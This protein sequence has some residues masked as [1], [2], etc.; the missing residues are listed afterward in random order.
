MWEYSMSKLSFPRKLRRQYWIIRAEQGVFSF[1]S[2]K[3]PSHKT[4]SAVRTK[5]LVP[6]FGLERAVVVQAT[7][8][9]QSVLCRCDFYLD[10]AEI[11]RMW[12]HVMCGGRIISYKLIT[13]V[14][15][16]EG[17]LM[18][19]VSQLVELICSLLLVWL[20]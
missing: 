11:D 3:G 7:Y 16:C 20:I 5:P 15:T 17:F 9:L 14:L 6:P 8:G 12:S 19:F 10:R 13:A 4:S 1:S 18:K 2:I